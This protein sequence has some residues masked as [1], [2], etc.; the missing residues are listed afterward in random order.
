MNQT[1]E[2]KEEYSAKIPALQVLANLGWTYISPSQCIEKRGSNR[3][4]LLKDELIRSLQARRFEWDGKEHALSPNAIEHIVRDLSSPGLHEGLLTANERIYDKLTLGITVKE[5]IDG[6]P[7]Q[8]TIPIIDWE[9]PENNLFHV[10][11]EMDV[12]SSAGTH[13]R[14]PDIV[15]FVNG[16]PFVVIEAK[17]PESGNPNK[18]MLDEGISQSIRNQK[19]DEIPQLFCY[20]QILMAISNTD[21]RYGTTKTDKK[22][23]ATWRE[24]IL[25]E[26]TFHTIKNTP[27]STTAKDSIFLNR[28]KGM[29]SYFESLWSK[30]VLPTQQDKLLISL[31]SKERLL[32]MIQYYIIFDKR[33]GKI[34][35]RYQQAF[36]IKAM[37]DRVKKTDKNGS[38][39]GGVI[40]HTTGSGKSFTMV[41]LSKALLLDPELRDCRIFIVTDRLDLE[42]QLS[43][44]FLTGGAFGSAVATKKE[45]ERAKVRSG[46]DLAQRIGKGDDRIIFSIID[47]FNTA[48]KLPE[49]YNPSDKIIVLVDEGHRSHGGETHERMRKALPNASYIAFTGTPLLKKDKT[50]NKFGPIIHAYTMQ[51]AVEDGTV[52]PLLYEERRPELDVNEKAIDK[53]FDRI[54][55]RLK[56]KQKT[57]L[58]KKFANKGAVYGS[59][60]RIELIAWDIATHFADNIK[61]LGM[62]LKGQ[63]AT[64]SKLSAIRY[65]KYLDE[66]GLV[67]SAV[68]ISPP[69]TREGHSSVDESALPEVQKW[70]KK[71]VG[72]SANAEQ[73]ERDVIESFGTDD[74]VDIL[75]VVDKLLTGFDEPRN[76][77]LYIDKPLKEH[78]LLQAIARVNRLHE[79]KD[80]GLL[81]DYRGILK[82]LDT[83]LKQYQDLQER[84]QSGFDM[85]DIEGLYHQVDTEYKK[86]PDLHKRLW[87]I[88][89]EVENRKDLEQYRQVLMP[90]YTE[91]EDGSSLDLRQKVR[92]DFYQALTQFGLCLKIALSSRSFFED[93]SFSEKDIARYKSDLKFFTNLR[94]I[95]RQD[96]QETVDYSAYEEQIRRLVDKHVVGES[97]AEPEGI[98][99]INE[100]GTEDPSEWTKEKTRNETDI[101]RTRV[102]KT[103]EQELNNDPYAQ[104]VFS[105]LLKDAI[106]QAE[107]MFEHPFKQYTLFKDFEEQLNSRAMAGIPKELNE[108]ETAKAYY[109]TFRLVL[110]EDHF[111]A[112]K[113]EEEKQLI[114]EAIA[115]DSIVGTAVVEHSLSPQAMESTIHKG[116]LPRLFKIIGL[117]KAK[118]VIEHIIQITRVRLTHGKK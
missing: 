89:S 48:S 117:D 52:T 96:A 10:T 74:G 41:F 6:K 8:P 100:L 111:K 97:I 108:S 95:A 118:D 88:F 40:W 33:V 34:V 56:D 11:E 67:T 85:D 46:R 66:T 5:F 49:C 103:I 72:N 109:G 30:D 58:K 87:R 19:N 93:G 2:T 113:P 98:V 39:E 20:A 104:K 7:V 86:L 53:W 102:R 80:Y 13:R 71:A 47:K 16:I 77:V 45:G 115:I 68:I 62:G 99:L 70:F 90:Q 64:D 114:D 1:P 81:I 50:Q 26:S 69:D 31:L 84:T 110:G 91:D 38:R 106:S 23:W 116:L 4:V 44:V 51:R 3:E 60:N 12:L 25:D 92:E 22:F 59:E 55:L 15:C 28:P 37:L 63:L 82:E 79:A 29:R 42:K 35:A 54:T 61:S 75:I 101:I 105:E 9:N 78:N 24:E 57:D 18:S 76:T 112:I 83:T 73:Y 107:K 17:R 32:K 43:R 36:G 65:K 94:K 27:L 14:I 21:G